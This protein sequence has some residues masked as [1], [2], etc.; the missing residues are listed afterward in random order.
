MAKEKDIDQSQLLDEVQDHLSDADAYLETLRED[1]DDFE[2][3]LINKLED[4]LSLK[5]NNRVF[6]PTLS[7]IVYERASRVM[8]QNPKGKAYAQSKDDVGKNMLMNLLLKHFYKNANEQASML[9]KLRLW[10]LYSLVYG[11][12]FALVPWRVDD[13][14]GYVGPELNLLPIR[15]CFPQPNKRNIS[16]M[17]WFIVRNVVSI[18]WLEAQDQNEWMNVDRLRA[19]VER[20]KDGGD[21]KPSD[22]DQ[23]SQ[24]ERTFFPSTYGDL[25]F[26][27]VEIYTEY[28]RDKWITWTPQRVDEK[29]SKPFILRVVGD[30]KNPPYPNGE[31]PIVAKHAFPLIDSPIGLGEFAR[32]SSLQMAIN[33]FWNLGLT[34]AKYKTF[35][36]L[37]INPDSV[38]PSSI[39]W[40]AGEFW[41]MNNPNVD[42]Q[43]MNLNG[44][45][46][47]SMY[48][49]I[50]A[51]K[52]AMEAQAGSTFVRQAA[53]SD[54]S[55]GK[56]PQAIKFMSEKESARDE[57]D[58][59][60]MEEAI[61]EVYRKWVALTTE[62]M[63]KKVTMR[64]FKEEIEEIQSQY[65]D[66]VELFESGSGGKVTVK[67]GDIDDMYDFVLETGSTTK[68]DIEA[69]QNNITA[70]LKAILE[71]PPIIEA[72]QAE[73]KTI[74]LPE[75]FKRW[76]IA[77]GTKDWD[78][79]IVAQEPEEV[80]NPE[81]GLSAQ[82]QELL[83]MA[84]GGQV[85][86]E[87]AVQPQPGIDVSQFSD[88][89]ILAAIQ[90]TMG[91]RLGNVPIQQ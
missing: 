72:L 22:D 85:P 49:A 87:A 58:R 32:G 65:P 28:R 2:A 56:T 6:D 53:N 11:T 54:T 73:G 9:I 55:L 75:L 36:P 7:T 33:S 60:M 68:V 63:E 48:N 67:K 12:M 3:L 37:H 81:Q 77:G 45:R 10:D 31:L 5:T 14:T 8:A 24:V 17:D 39:V 90:Q 29:T 83:A 18:D 38:V 84:Q 43:P 35:P 57:W 71:N 25:A 13:R 23:R 74:N 89:D 21:I 82:D 42:V 86:P 76:L 64:L 20:G 59:V 78:K 88:P 70:I 16:D 1:W 51:L 15:D 69:E 62:N 44:I 47:D 26:P 79:V 80:E 34:G 40:E 52:S 66:A 61:T 50:G 19:A 30:E 27:N 46:E 91:E 41:F 4:G